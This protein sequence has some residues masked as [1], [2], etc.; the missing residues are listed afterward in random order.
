MEMK[1]PAIDYAD[2]AEYDRRQRGIERHVLAAFLGGLA[3]GLVGMFVSQSGPAW[4]LHLYDPYAYLALA[5]AL[6]VTAQGFGWAALSTFLA[7][8]STLVAAMGASA[9][10]GGDFTFDIIGGSASG[11]NWILI[12]L[13][14]LGLLAYVTRRQDHWGDLAAGA[15]GGALLADVVDRSTPGFIAVESGFWPAVAAVVGGLSIAVVIAL[16]HTLA[17]RLRA[18]VVSGVLAGVA[19]IVLTDELWGPFWAAF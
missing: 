7:A 9:L 4:L 18:L 13:V 12:M 15:V 16:R 19:A 8:V 6:G 5:I 3:V 1:R 10:R 17:G 11:L 2:F 14:G